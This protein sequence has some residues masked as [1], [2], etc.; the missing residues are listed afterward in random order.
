[1]AGADRPAPVLSLVDGLLAGYGVAIPVGAVAPLLI[2]LTARTGW[3]AGVAAALGV[4]TVDGCYALVAVLGGNAL[5]PLVARVAEPLRWAAVAVVVVISVRTA[6]SAL[7]PG[8]ASVTVATPLR[9]Y[10]A[11]LGLTALN[12][13]TVVYFA[14]L[15]LGRPAYGGFLFV[16][17]VSLASA[18]W[19]L[20][21]AGGG[22]LLGAVLDSRRG[23]LVTALVASAVILGL[24]VRLAL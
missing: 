16:L 17:G 18:S 7:R 5:A 6:L 8:G 9:A 23:R 10:L 2:T 21:L 13:T 11:F 3:R 1:M 19:Q 14:A 4:A 24:A 22:R 20:L 12:P 15:V